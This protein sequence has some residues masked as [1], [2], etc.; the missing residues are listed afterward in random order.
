MRIIAG[1][2]KGRR[3]KSVSGKNTRPTADRVKEALFS[4]IAAL[5]PDAKFLDLFAGT[6]SVGM[7]AISRG[8][9]S[10]VFV[11]ASESSVRVIQ[12]N[13]GLCGFDDRGLVVRMDGLEFLKKKAAQLAPFD[14]VFLDPPYDI[15]LVPKALHALSEHK[16]IL[17]DCGWVIVEARKGSVESE[18]EVVGLE[19]FRQAYYGD[20][21][22]VFYRRDQ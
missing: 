19:R 1:E 21:V 12:E 8:A 10:A 5:V 22:L 4:I 18:A 13:L 17:T 6:G 15:G 2:A 14:L 16:G 9:K 3:L 7:E 20:T 11:D